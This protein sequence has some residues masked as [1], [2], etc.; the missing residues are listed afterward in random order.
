M[1][2]SRVQIRNFRNF[3]NIDVPMSKNSVLIGEN[4]SGKSN[5][6]HALRLVLDTSLPDRSRNLKIS[7]F[8]D[9]IEDPFAEG[10]RSIEIDVDFVGFEANPAT[11]ALLADFRV[12]GDHTVARISY[13]FRPDCEGEP[14]SEADFDYT[15]FGGGDETRSVPPK[16]RKRLVLDVLHAL[17]DA[18]SD[19]ANWRKSPLRP[20]VEDAFSR[21]PDSDL[22]SVSS[23]IESAGEALLKLT[24]ITT[25][26]AKLRSK[27][28]AIGG[29]RNDIDAKFG[30]VSTDPSRLANI[31]KLFIDGGS[32]DIGDA[33]LGSA[34]LALLTLQLA[35][36]EWKRAQNE[37]DFTI[38]AIEEPE[39]HLHPQLQRKVF[40]TLFQVSQ[41]TPQ[42]L[43]V[44][45]HSPN[46]ASVTPFNQIVL[47]RSHG[48]KGT[49]AHSLARLELAEHEIDDLQ[50]YLTTTRAEV[51][52]SRGVIF[53]EGPSEEALLPAFSATLGY[54][55]DALGITVCSVDGID[56][57]PY[58]KLATMLDIPFSV[59]TDWDPSDGGN[60]LG[61]ERAKKLLL[62]NRE[63]AGKVAAT[64][65]Q[66]SRLD[67]EENFLRGSAQ[68]HSIFLNTT[69]L[70]TELAQDSDLANILLSILSEQTS[71]GQTL[72]TRIAKYQANHT[73]IVPE[74]LMLMIGYVGKG[75]FS[76]ELAKRIGGIEPPAYVKQ[77]IENVVARV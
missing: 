22:V 75:R 44:T 14:S 37:Q 43:I 50:G 17:R 63:F 18:E 68:N 45:T 53:V 9:G 69:T 60:P 8:W 70:E 39:A 38:I 58:V 54:D 4:R 41:E 46:I 52:F 12:A 15:I 1:H 10:G 65:E 31:L 66:I 47:L 61:W 21:V 29:P 76:R 40:S 27:L 2:I 26:E 57:E 55:L 28:L 5:F 77:A 42:S 34:N 6:I 32:R 20:L 51:F 74:K 56:F 3:K 62:T 59:V 25:L 64:S 30:I 7:D 48:D 19:L 67:A 24:E 71:F 16:T 36:Y 73:E 35:E 33:S 72:K 23:A 11:H 49:V 13:R